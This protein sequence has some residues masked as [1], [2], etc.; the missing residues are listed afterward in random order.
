MWSGRLGLSSVMFALLGLR[1]GS[2]DAQASPPPPAPASPAAPTTAPPARNVPPPASTPSTP[3]AASVAP[4]AEGAGAAGNAAG[5]DPA[6]VAAAVAAKAS[7]TLLEVTDPAAIA[8]CRELGHDSAAS[9]I[10]G[11]RGHLQLRTGLRER[12]LRRG[13]SHL[14]YQNYLDGAV[15]SEA[16]Q[17][18]DCAGTTADPAASGVQAG[19]AASAAAAA[20][21]GS[22]AIQLD[23]IP[24]GSLHTNIAGIAADADTQTTVGISGNLDWFVSRYF[25]FGF[26][27]GVILGLKGTGDT[28]S[29]T[30]LDLRASVAVGPMAGA[31]LAV[32]GYAT[33]GGSWLFLPGNSDSSSGATLGLGVAARYRIADSEFLTFDVGYQFG[34]QS[35]MVQGTDVDL[36]SNVLHLGIGVGT[37]FGSGGPR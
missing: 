17:F 30:Q 25:A 12:G 27:P 8:S 26:A 5:P 1:A 4:A 24:A 22:V 6:L 31:G 10:A 11:A 20:P 7:G 15:Q 14:R 19:A 18:Y 29:A 28:A 2:A 21:V 35:M 9:A 34:S 32:H 33:V 3:G 37:Y 16:A 13:A 23:L 36:A